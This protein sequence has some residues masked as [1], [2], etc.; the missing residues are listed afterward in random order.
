MSALGA[1]PAIPAVPGM[2]A[3]PGI[4]G[5]LQSLLTGFPLSGMIGYVTLMFLTVFPITGIAG[6]NLIAVG[7]PITAFLKFA[8]VAISVVIMTFLSPYLPY[9]IQ[10][11]W[12]AWIAG[13]GPWYIFDI[14]QM[15]NY[16]DFQTNGFR[17][18]IPIA[19]IPSG[20]GKNS[21]WNLTST[22]INL[23]LATIA[24]SGQLIPALFP[25][26]SIMGVSTTSI[27]N[28]VSIGSGSV[29]G[30]SALASIAAVALGPSMAPVATAA[31]GALKGGGNGNSLPPLSQFIDSLSETTTVQ[32]GGGSGSGSIGEM[33]KSDKMFLSVLGFVGVVGL[34]LGFAR[35]KGNQ[36]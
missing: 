34:A 32:S 25:N 23:F 21:S 5:V 2:A 28:A 3:A 10:G 14:I 24:G 36:G 17:S 18:M 30:V 4:T 13:I 35:S 26:V 8:S 33:T 12:M 6:L 15:M 22:F 27:G 19:L 31:L 20:G 1:I 9:I 16:S 7:Q 29:L 11:R